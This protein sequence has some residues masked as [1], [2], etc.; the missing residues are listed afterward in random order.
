MNKSTMFISRTAKSNMAV[1]ISTD[2][3][4]YQIWL[5]IADILTRN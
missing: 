3:T 2:A 5:C 4:D 1:H